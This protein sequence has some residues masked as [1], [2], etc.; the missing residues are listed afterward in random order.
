MKSE[1]DALLFNGDST[2][3]KDVSKMHASKVQSPKMAQ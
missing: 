1:L 3:K 2:E